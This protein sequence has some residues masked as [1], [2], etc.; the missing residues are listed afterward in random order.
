MLTSR[1]F[2]RWWKVLYVVILMQL[3]I[4]NV[5]KKDSFAIFLCKRGAAAAWFP[6]ASL[7]WI[8]NIRSLGFLFWGFECPVFVLTS[9]FTHVLSSS[10]FIVQIHCSCGS[11]CPSRGICYQLW[12]FK[13]DLFSGTINEQYYLVIL[14]VVSYLCGCKYWWTGPGLDFFLVLGWALDREGPKADFLWIMFTST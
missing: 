4:V 13:D 2:Q 6:A 10:Y 11:Y 5:I 8:Q 14:S 1:L 7:P 9:S 3:N 12:L